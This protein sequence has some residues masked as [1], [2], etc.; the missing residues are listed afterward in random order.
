MSSKRLDAEGSNLIFL[1][2]L[3][4][5]KWGKEAKCPGPEPGPRKNLLIALTMW[6]MEPQMTFRQLSEQ[7]NITQAHYDVELHF[8]IHEA[9]G[10]VAFQV[11]APVIPESG[12]R[13]EGHR[14]SF[15]SVIH[16][17]GPRFNASVDF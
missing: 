15:L 9:T 11:T 3:D 1:L 6:T 13:L 2:G 14:L 10:T 7:R 12:R 17:W 16:A 8:R 5:R 4:P